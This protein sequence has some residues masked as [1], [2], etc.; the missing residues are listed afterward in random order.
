M[1]KVIHKEIEGVD[2]EI[3]DDRGCGWFAYFEGTPTPGELEAVAID[4]YPC[5]EG[6]LVVDQLD[7]VFFYPVK[8]QNPVASMAGLERW[9]ICQS[10]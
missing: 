9:Y 1:A 6:Q 3:G 2:A 8:C 4:I 5:D 7:E 10:V